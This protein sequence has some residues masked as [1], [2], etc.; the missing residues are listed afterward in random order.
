MVDKDPGKIRKMFGLIAPRYDCLNHLLSLSIDRYW[1][2]VTVRKLAPLLSRD[3]VILDLCTGTGDLALELSRIALVVGC[4][5]CHPMLVLGQ[6]KLKESQLNGQVRLVEGDAL[7]L[8]FSSRRFDAV[9]IAFGLRNLKEYQ[10]GL[11]EM[12][13]VL[14]RRGVLAVLE[15]SRPQTPIF[16][17]LYLFYLTNVLP[18]LGEWISGRKGA[19]SY[20]VESVQEFP[21]PKELSE[22][23]SQ[24]GFGQISCYRLTGGIVTL[25]VAQKGD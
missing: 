16:R 23:I 3:P 8:P 13:R 15:F 4:D 24:V 11:R 18:R 20:L 2:R 25:H 17:Q 5:F 10:Q 21:I 12:Y 1:R 19:Y 9:T 22:M 14:R 7:R 6:K